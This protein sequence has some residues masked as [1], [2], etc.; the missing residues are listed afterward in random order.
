MLWINN[1]SSQ[2]PPWTCFCL[3]HPSYKPGRMDSSTGEHKP[4]ETCWDHSFPFLCLPSVLPSN[5][6]PQIL[7]PQI[8]TMPLPSC[9]KGSLCWR[10]CGPS[11]LSGGREITLQLRPALPEHTDSPSRDPCCPPIPGKSHCSLTS[12]ITPVYRIIKF[13]L[14]VTSQH[15]CNSSASQAF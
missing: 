12:S 11:L 14:L 2:L 8:Q 15:G 9:S 7:L 5:R 4:L 10:G 1:G 6:V 3:S 13:Y